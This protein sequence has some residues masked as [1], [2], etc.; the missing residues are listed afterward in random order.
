MWLLRTIVVSGAIATAVANASASE[1]RFGNG[2]FV[3][4]DHG[5]A[6]ATF[7]PIDRARPAGDVRTN[8]PT[9]LGHQ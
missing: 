2:D 9:R 3:G 1:M 8:V 7:A 4:I 5:R 6:A